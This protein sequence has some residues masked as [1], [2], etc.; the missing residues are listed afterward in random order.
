MKIHLI[1]IGGIGLSAIAKFLNFKG[2]SVSGSDMCENSI[3]MEL[4]N[5]GRSY[6][7][8]A[9]DLGLSKNTVNDIVRRERVKSI[10]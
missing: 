7:W 1:G 8:I 4:V 9:R 3:T 5:E 2:H 6:R 10:Q